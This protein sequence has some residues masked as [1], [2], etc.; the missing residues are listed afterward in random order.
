MSVIKRIA[1][2]VLF[3]GMAVTVEGQ[4]VVLDFNDTLHETDGFDTVNNTHGEPSQYSYS[5]DGLTLTVADATGLGLGN[6]GNASANFADDPVI[7]SGSSGTFLELTADNGN[8]F[9]VNSIDV[10]DFLPAHATGNI[11]STVTFY[12]L[13]PDNSFVSSTF[14]F[15]TSAYDKELHSFPAEFAGLSSF[16]WNQ[17]SLGEPPAPIIG[18]LANRVHMVDNLSI[19]LQGPPPTEPILEIDRATGAISIENISADSLQILGYSILSSNGA[20]DQSGWTTISGNFDATPANGGTGDGTVDMDDRWHVLSDSDVMTDLSEAELVLGD[21]GTVASGQS[22]ELGTPWVANPFGTA[23]LT[24]QLLLGD[25]TLMDIDVEFT[26]PEI[27]SGDIAGA[28]I[29]DGPDGSLDIIDW[30]DFRANQNA[31]LSGLSIAQ[32]YQRGDLDGDLDSDL[33]D[34]VL[35]AA[36]YNSVN[37]AGAFQAMVSRVPEPN[38]LAIALVTGMLAVA[39]RYH[40]LGRTSIKVFLALMTTCLL[41]VLQ[42]GDARAALDGFLPSSSFNHLYTPAD[43]VGGVDGWNGTGLLGGAVGN[44]TDFFVNG[45]D[46]LEYNTSAAGGGVWVKQDSSP[47]VWIDEIGADTSYTWEARIKMEAP[48][49][50]G[51]HSTYMWMENAAS[52]GMILSISNNGSNIDGDTSDNTDDFHNYRVAFDAADDVFHVW[53]DGTQLTDAAG[54]P[55]G[56]PSGGQRLIFGD[57]SSSILSGTV[58]TEYLRIDTTGAYTAFAEPELKLLVNKSTGLVSIVNDGTPATGN[59]TFNAYSIT[60]AAGALEYSNWTS[61]QSIDL[62]GNGVPDDGIGWEQFETSSDSYLSEAFLTG[63]SSLGD[64]DAPISL[65]QSFDTSI[66]GVGVDGDLAFS[67][68]DADGVLHQGEVHY[69]TSAGLLGDFNGDEIVNIADY[70][71]WRNNLGGDESVL[72]GNGNNNGTVDEGDYSLWKSN[73]GTAGSGS[74]SVSA[75]TVPEPSSGIA[76]VIALALG[77]TMLVSRRRNLCWQRIAITAFAMFLLSTAHAATTLDREYRLG[78]DG[79]G[80]S[81][82]STVGAGNGFGTTFDSAGTPGAGDLQDLIPS[83][84]LLHTKVG[85]SGGR[86]GAATEDLGIVFDGTDDLLYT[87]FSMNAPTQMWDN[88]T[89]FPSGFPHNYEGIYSHGIQFWAKPNQTVLT[90]GQRQDLVIDTPENGVYITN[91]GNWGLQFDGG[92]DSGVDVAGT[93]DSNGWAHVMQLGGIVDLKN[94]SSPSQGA[95][96]VN[97]VAVIATQSNQTFD[98]SSSPLSI[99]ASVAL[100]AEGA[101]SS[102]S[103]H[104]TG[105]LDDVGLFFWGNNTG[106]TNGGAG[107]FGQDWG[108]F[109]LPEDNEWISMELDRLASL[110]GVASIPNGDVNLDGIV[111]GDGTGPATTDDVTAFIDG[112]LFTTAPN[113]VQ[114]GDWVSRQNGDLNYDGITNLADAFI[115]HQGLLAAGSAGFDFSLLEG[116]GVPEPPTTVIAMVGLI[117]VVLASRYRFINP[118]P[119]TGINVRQQ[120][121]TCDASNGT[122]GNYSRYA[123]SR[124]VAAA[125]TLVELLVVIAIIGILVALLL[126]AVQAAREAA[127]RTQCQNHFKQVGLALHNYEGTH[128]EL[129]YGQAA[130]SCVSGVGGGSITEA[131]WAWGAQILPYMEDSSL[132]DL[133]DFKKNPHQQLDA[134]R[135]FVDVYLCP[136]DPQGRELVSFT[137]FIEG[138]QDAAKTNMDAIVDSTDHKCG[139]I[140]V[141]H[142]SEKPDGAFANF[143]SFKFRQFTDGLSNTLFVCEVTGAGEGTN[144]SHCWP[145]LNSNDTAGGING[146]NTIPGDGTWTYHNNGPSSFHPGGCHFLMGDGSVQF[147]QES[148]EPGAL[149]AM[150]SRNRGDNAETFTPNIPV[151]GPPTR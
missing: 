102:S 44:G 67:Y 16:L 6:W 105:V 70:T 91:S 9:A 60:S 43:I 15:Q 93:V 84:F 65:G 150:T 94:G 111:S 13:K 87:P 62:D 148:I 88:A 125:F 64:Q 134:I 122:L 55:A 1:A 86:P 53:R 74:G 85:G 27:I 73:F 24:V 104:F 38:S 8:V 146:P 69:V 110:A 142:S 72:L 107:P 75:A 127:R 12:G 116:I 138:L 32:A 78:D 119:T 101:L 28:T 120:I 136:S 21:G 3:T 143:S 29:N 133:I 80:A 25:G 10:I 5:S 19:T 100:N 51:D 4:T 81:D 137:N 126:P 115:L 59:V 130:N 132:H 82:G 37:G 34:F 114:I 113:G 117:V 89:F 112:W 124:A 141:K 121:R 42:A 50:P 108:A 23:D 54:L 90:A 45:D 48:A 151:I 131:R 79:E 56:N 71:V 98:A 63:M 95:L 145:I 7:A 46:Q 35:F 36:A 96:Y 40:G 103:N 97:G 92:G 144:S 123:G 57:G 2:A 118:K 49:T 76:A 147:L 30:L 77:G 109:S 149:G 11:G 61:L 22:I 26:G 66:F 68:T 58:L 52:Q 135:T 99:G 139:G 20:L 140:S 31:D 33:I 41:G 18:A 47:S 39:F 83:G 129:P 106:Q 128:R 14:S 17:S